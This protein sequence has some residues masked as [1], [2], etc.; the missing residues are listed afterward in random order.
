MYD[1]K[2]VEYMLLPRLCALTEVLWTDTVWHDEK[3]FYKRVLQNQHLLDTFHVNYS[4]TWH[5]PSL[6]I[7]GGEKMPSLLLTLESKVPQS[8]LTAW[9]NDIGVSEFT[10]YSESQSIY[11]TGEFL[12]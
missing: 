12:S 2:Q 10:T 3:S 8:I 1:E 4:N 9:G 5:L 6:K 11:S 7:K